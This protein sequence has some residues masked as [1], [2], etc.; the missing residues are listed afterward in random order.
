MIIVNSLIYFLL[1]DIR[2]RGYNDHFSGV[3][4]CRQAVDY[5]LVDQIITELHVIS[6]DCPKQVINSAKVGSE[7]CAF[8]HL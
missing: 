6:L 1:A 4:L 5:D 7:V 3:K 8:S 2:E